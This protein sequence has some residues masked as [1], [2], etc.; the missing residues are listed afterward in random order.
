MRR[1]MQTIIA[2]PSSAASRCLEVVDEVRGDQLEPL[3][4]PDERLELRPLAT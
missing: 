4:G 1:L 3:L 2:L